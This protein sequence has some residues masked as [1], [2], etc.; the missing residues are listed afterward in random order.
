MSFQKVSIRFDYRKSFTLV[1]AI[2]YVL[3]FYDLSITSV[4]TPSHIPHSNALYQYIMRQNKDV[5]VFSILVIPKTVEVLP[6]F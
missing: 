1:N 5:L 2:I 4:S 3:Q 6:R